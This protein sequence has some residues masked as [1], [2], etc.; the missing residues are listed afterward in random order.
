MDLIATSKGRS[1]LLRHDTGAAGLTLVPAGWV[2]VQDLLGALEQ[3]G[4]H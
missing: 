4:D 2:E 3:A 1:Y